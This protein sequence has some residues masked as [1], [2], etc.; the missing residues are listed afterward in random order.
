MNDWWFMAGIAL[1]LLITLS[2]GVQ[3]ERNPQRRRR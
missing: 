1:A 3:R 2:L